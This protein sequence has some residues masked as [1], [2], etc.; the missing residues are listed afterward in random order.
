MKVRWEV[1]SVLSDA[2]GPL[3]D[4]TWYGPRFDVEF[5]TPANAAL[6]FN[7]DAFLP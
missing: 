3:H 1:G 7:P 4:G 5:L 6:S 2:V